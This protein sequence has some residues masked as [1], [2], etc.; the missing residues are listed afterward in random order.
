MENLTLKD[1]KYIAKIRGLK[2]NINL[3]KDK[4]IDMLRANEPQYPLTERKAVELKIKGYGKM[5]KAQL[6]QALQNSQKSIPTTPPIPTPSN[7]RT[8]PIPTPRIRL[9]QKTNSS[10]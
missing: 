2:N 1:L 6:L 7:I 5:T 9:P 8:P 10:S 3:R 4:L